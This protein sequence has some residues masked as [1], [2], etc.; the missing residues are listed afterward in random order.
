M[1]QALLGR[2]AACTVAS[3]FNGTWW[4]ET[5]NSVERQSHLAW[6]FG[7]VFCVDHDDL[8]SSELL[9]ENLL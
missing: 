6:I 3:Q 5:L 2:S 7:I 1:T 9:V 4:L 8:T